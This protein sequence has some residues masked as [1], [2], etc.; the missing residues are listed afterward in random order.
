[1]QSNYGIYIYM[2][3]AQIMYSSRVLYLPVH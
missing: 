1:M 3:L 2:Q